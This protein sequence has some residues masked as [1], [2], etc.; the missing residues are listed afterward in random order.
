MTVGMIV[1]LPQQCLRD[2][3]FLVLDPI[4]GDCH[5]KE[6]SSQASLADI[7]ITQQARHEMLHHVCEDSACL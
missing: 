1:Q 4:T 6:Y 5:R 7:D 3:S 2:A